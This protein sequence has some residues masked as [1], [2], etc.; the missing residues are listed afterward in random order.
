MAEGGFSIFQAHFSNFAKFCRIDE[1]CFLG[2]GRPGGKSWRR[3]GRT[4]G[5]H[6][7][8]FTVRMETE[9]TYLFYLVILIGALLCP[10]GRLRKPSGR[11]RLG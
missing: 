7:A 1:F 8:S 2:R 9:L 3:R 4:I 6:I 5:M 10:V 11:P